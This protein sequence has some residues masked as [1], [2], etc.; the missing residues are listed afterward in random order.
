MF[1]D[2]VVTDVDYAAL[3]PKA[4]NRGLKHGLIH[5]AL[6]GKRFNEPLF[7]LP[8]KEV[9]ITEERPLQAY[10]QGFNVGKV[11]TAAE[12]RMV[13]RTLCQFDRLH[14][15]NNVHRIACAALVQARQA[16]VDQAAWE[17]KLLAAAR[18]SG[19]SR[20]QAIVINGSTD[21]HDQLMESAMSHMIK[22]AT[23]Q[24]LHNAFDD[25]SM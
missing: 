22:K 12:A 3:Y 21:I 25:W 20:E 18:G 15:Y 23:V 8:P 13:W 1:Q 14:T 9:D 5:R 19:W 6:L 10:H 11:A 7:D 4:Y 16:A 2:Y 17:T 24:R